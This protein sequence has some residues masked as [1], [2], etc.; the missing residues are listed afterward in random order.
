LISSFRLKT[1]NKHLVK[2]LPEKKILY[3]NSLEEKD[4]QQWLNTLFQF[5]QPADRLSLELDYDLYGDGEAQLAWLDQSV[6]IL[7]SQKNAVVIA[8]EVISHIDDHIKQLKLVP[9][10][11]KFFIETADPIAI[12]WKKKIS[13]TTTA[14]LPSYNTEQNDA[15]EVRLLINA[16]VQTEPLVL[17]KIVND[18]L[19]QIA[20][21]HDCNIMVEKW[22]AFKPGYP[23]PV[24][25]IS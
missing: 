23:K 16:R 20:R 19:K 14:P 13:I 4:I 3:Q 15:R 7:S 17:Q 21:K 6:T 11:L 9:G 12:G 25:R 1:L 8:M 24:H 18:T 5:Q 22:S 2:E 10:H